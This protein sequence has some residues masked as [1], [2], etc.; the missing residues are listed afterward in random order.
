M[1]DQHERCHG[2]EHGDLNFLT[3]AGSFAVEQRHRRDVEHG[4]AG[5]LVRHDGAHLVGWRERSCTCGFPDAFSALAAGEIDDAANVAA[6]AQV[7]HRL[8]D[9]VELIVA[10]NQLV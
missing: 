9:L 8:V 5:D 2:F 1:L 4:S 10:G 6:F 3:F 7:R